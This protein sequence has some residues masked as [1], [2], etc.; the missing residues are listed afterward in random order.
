MS[1]IFGNKP[2][3]W[4]LSVIP[5]PPVPSLAKYH[6]FVKA[7]YPSLCPKDLKILDPKFQNVPMCNAIYRILSPIQK[8]PSPINHFQDCQAILRILSSSS[9]VSLLGERLGVNRS[10]FESFMCLTRG[11]SFLHKPFFLCKK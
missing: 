5:H 11:L 2:A 4:S 3:Y 10:N 1:K 7:K 9:L 6:A 8:D